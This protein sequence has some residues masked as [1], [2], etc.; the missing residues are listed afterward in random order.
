MDG[1]MTERKGRS[2]GRAWLAHESI[3]R[4]LL[5]EWCTNLDNGLILE[6]QHFVDDTCAPDRFYAHI[7][8]RFVCI[9]PRR[10]TLDQQKT[11]N[12]ITR[13][14]VRR[15]GHFKR[16]AGILQDHLI[17]RN[18]Q[19]LGRDPGVFG[20]EARLDSMLTCRRRRRSRQKKVKGT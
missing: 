9:Q 13:P 7:D 14:G 2:W 3:R 8:G 15:E 1:K 16:C 20:R 4:E 17:H 19:V 12:A 18:N 11:H 10:E 5:G 6:H